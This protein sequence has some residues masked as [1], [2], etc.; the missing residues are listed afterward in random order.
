MQRILATYIK[1]W[2]LMRRDLGGLALLFLMPVLLITIMALVQDAPFKDYKN[3]KFEALFLNQDGGKVAAALEQ[4]LR[5]SGQF[6]LVDSVRIPNL[7][8]GDL[9]RR[10]QAGEFQLAIV[11]P[12]GVS[13]EIYNSAN[14]IANEMGK[15]MGMLGSLPHRNARDS[16]SIKVLFDPVAKPAFRLAILNAIQHFTTR[17][18]FDVIMERLRAL[19]G[20]S[21]TTRSLDIEKQLQSV[22]VREQLIHQKSSGL[23]KSNSV[24]HNVPAWAIFGMFFMVIVICENMISERKGGSWNRLKS[25]PGPFFH[26]LI[27]KMVFYIVMGILQFALMLVV[28]VYMMPLLG[29]NSLELGPSAVYLPI[30]VLA[31][32]SCSTAF[33]I[34]VG[35]V[36]KTTSQAL[37]V[38]AVLVV[39]LSALGGIWVPLEVLPAS[40]KAFSVVSPLRWS[41]EGVNTLL[42]RHGTLGDILLPVSILIGLSVASMGLAW[43][44]ERR[45]SGAY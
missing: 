40:L 28:G 41:L 26:L 7:D 6:V 31:I 29:L 9:I 27:G 5:E 10:I 3:H 36:F 20:H 34:L 30:M 22:G 39:I 32:A 14:L 19:S 33:G 38:S 25:I 4:G 37:S 17:I 1:E 43:F 16:V 15:Q 13:S 12:Q 21:D 11:I 2:H 18:Q 45:Q 35:T 23:E 8:S 24:Q 42:L 44:V